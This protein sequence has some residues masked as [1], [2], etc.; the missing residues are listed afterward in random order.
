MRV[1]LSTE[2][3]A[4][5][6]SRRP[7]VTI[8]AWAA[9]LVVSFFIV[10]A[11][12]E[13]ALTTEFEFTNSPESERAFVLLEERLRGPTPANEA[14]IVRSDSLTVDDPAFR[15]RV[16]AI[17]NE[18]I[19]LEDDNGQKVFASGLNYVD[20]EEGG[21]VFIAQALVSNDRHITV[22]PFVMAGDFDQANTN[23]EGVLESVRANDGV[24]GFDVLVTGQASISFET[25]EVSESDLGREF[26][27]GVPAAIVILILLFGAL[28]ATGVPLV[29]TA[30]SI[31]GALALTALIGQT[32]Q[33]SFF[34]TNM[35]FMIGLAV[36][37]DYSLFI[38]SRYREERSKG[39]EKM[40]AIARS[41]ATAS[42]AVFFSGVTVVFAL[43]GMLIVPTSIFLSLALGAILVVIVSVAASLTLLPAILGLLGDRVNAL[44]VPYLARRLNRPA[45]DGRGGVWNGVTNVVMRHPV[46]S[47]VLT[48]AFLIA[49]AIPVFDIKTGFNGIS[50]LPER[51]QTR[52]AFEILNDPQNGFSFGLVSPAE[53][54]IDGD[55]GSDS[56]QAGI[57]RLR[58]LLAQDSA[59]DGE[60]TVQVNEAGDLALVSI[61]VN[62]DPNTEVAL[63]AIDRL[64]EDIVPGAFE[65]VPAKVLVTGITA[66]NSDFF[67]VVA[68]F[69][70][71][72]F[73]VV[74]GLS[75]ILLTIAF[76]SIVIPIK[77]IVMNLLSVGAAYG[78]MVLVTQKGFLAE[79]LGF[80][81]VERI[82]AWIPLF[83]F[84][85]LFGLSMDYQ[86]FLLSRIRERYDQ[87]RD[88]DE[89]VAFGLRSTAGLIIGAALIMVA[90][91]A[92]F[93]AGEL[94]GFQQVGFGLGVAIFLDATVVRSILVPSTMKLLGNRNW[95]FPKALEWLPDMRVEGE[96]SPRLPA[97]RARPGATTP[98]SA[99]G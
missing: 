75:F 89:A 10:G 55:I 94:A 15:A 49:A 54:V 82:E 25:N 99:D 31:I 1:N 37:I 77:A 67:D 83:M 70:P 24:D 8:G 13:D 79:Q 71:I 20:V 64:R 58:E 43:I 56:V 48:A 22:M 85:V 81:Q 32:F 33:L 95:Y 7:W 5:A 93:A 90:V 97:T 45:S 29:L 42:R 36:G 69:T 51:L 2:G 30:F 47:L 91:F 78:I 6:S 88:N 80:Q 57:Q 59:F 26:T 68:M 17:F 73:A 21:S 28:V 16:Q 53:I 76:R 92:G 62:G 11:L 87:T 46:V 4:R 44:R 38:L 96:E 35:I 19:N 3:L 52:E 18:L 9:A 14:V 98:S 12:L 66:F 60:A 23:I 86:V 74:L 61:A 39:V 50:T 40:E 84:S 34:V 63:R 72:V 65:G 27:I 41:G